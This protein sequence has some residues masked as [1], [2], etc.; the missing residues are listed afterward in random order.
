MPTELPGRDRRARRIPAPAGETRSSVA[1]SA[2][3]IGGG[4]A[5][6]A[7]AFGLAERGVRVQLV[8][9]SAEL[10]GRVRSW[11]VDSPAGEVTMSRG[12]HAFF[13]QYY[14]LRALLSRA[15]DLS[16]MLAPVEDY[17][18]LSASGDRDS[19]A[20]I[21]RTPPWNFISFVARSETFSLADLRRVDIGSALGLL[22]VDFPRTYRD[23][24][25]VSAATF[26]D[27]LRFPDR[28]RHLALE[29]FARSFFADPREFS[30]GELVAMFHSYF[31]GSAEGL[32]FDVPADD[33]DQ[34]LWAP[35]GDALQRLGAR[36]IVG[37]AVHV[38][39]VAEA[40]DGQERGWRTSL[41]DGS[42]LEADAIVLAA[43]P[44][45]TRDLVAASSA[46]GDAAW[47]ERI[48]RG[49]TAPPFAVWRVWTDAPVA[50][51]RPAFLGTSG[52]G[53]LDNVTVLERYEDGAR[54]WA[55]EHGG[56][57]IELHAYALE[58]ADAASCDT[59]ALRRTLRDELAR[60][61][62]ETR[63][64]S[65]LHEELLVE[66][67]CALVGTDPWD[68]R[69]GVATPEREVKLAGDWVRS[70]LPIALMERAAT[71]GWIA[72]NE[73]LEQW[74]LAGHELWTVPTERRHSWPHVLRKLVDGRRER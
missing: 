33:F 60:V 2:T 20:K 18:V 46:L 37:E 66:E 74:G 56:S 68:E 5:G 25:G 17:P 27:R 50:P 23:Y 63:D 70:E 49:R 38:E 71:T 54:R 73:L 16:G 52:F 24:D 53:P 39:R 45:A 72:A 19:F 30:A 31:L 43:G 6:L 42:R 22:D 61:Y 13:R 58:D 1:R 36:R 65:I 7:A 11:R 21:P 44:G 69:P 14:N 26:L 57:V 32:L 51:E 35:L 40:P 12:F 67:D 48:A 41:A 3:V 8:E 55:D 4:I 62:P 10:G 9:P 29:V 64:L 15:G 28:A 47:R 59:D 34:T